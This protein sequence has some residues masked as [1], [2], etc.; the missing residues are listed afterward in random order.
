MSIPLFR[1]AVG[2]GPPFRVFHPMVVDPRQDLVEDLRNAVEIL[3][4]QLA[5]VQLSV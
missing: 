3:E 1:L 2:G 5:V 4:R